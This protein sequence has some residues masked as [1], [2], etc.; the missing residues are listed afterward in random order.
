VPRGK[1]QKQPRP[2]DRANALSLETTAKERAG[3][4]ARLNDYLARTG[5]HRDDF[6][7]RIN[8]SPVT[9]RK[10][11]HDSYH[12][13]GGSD[14]YLRQ[15]IESYIAAHPIAP[16]TSITGE[17]YDT[18]N[19]RLIRQTFQ[20]LLPRP[21]AY[22]IYAPPGSQ[23]TFALE[24]EV[25]RLNRDELSKNGHGRRAYYVYGRQSLRPLDLMKRVAAACGVPGSNNIDR[26]IIN[27]RHEFRTRRVL[28][29]LDEAQHLEIECFEVLRELL[30]QPPHMSLLFAGSHDLKQKFDRFSATLE[31]WNSRII[32]KVR[33]RGLQREEAEGIIQ[34]E[35]GDVLGRMPGERAAQKVDE[36]IQLATSK[37]AFEKGRTYINVR[38]LT[39]ALAQIRSMAVDHKEAVVA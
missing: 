4:I 25:A 28:L 16:P 3:C 34:R 27:L 26:I 21:V 23:K 18:E 19:V 22:M 8:Y 36:L 14:E 24:N 32:E 9:L 39:N 37:D 38:T 15:A 5:L 6:A 29:V 1:G 11:Q 2:A 33:L 12:Q 31:Q 10:F 30:D 7:N 35:V 13:V 20:N 17:L